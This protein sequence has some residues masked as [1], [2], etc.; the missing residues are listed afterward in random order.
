MSKALACNETERQRQRQRGRD[1]IERHRA[2]ETK[3]KGKE[4]KGKEEEGEKNWKWR[5]LLKQSLGVRDK[6]PSVALCTP[7]R[8]LKSPFL[9][10][11]KWLTNGKKMQWASLGSVQIEFLIIPLTFHCIGNSHLVL[12]VS[13]SYSW[14][15]MW[16][17]YGYY[18]IDLHI[19]SS[20]WKAWPDSGGASFNSSLWRQREVSSLV[21]NV[22]SRTAR[23]H[24]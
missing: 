20:Q 15:G 5:H 10:K 22:G 13:W 23:V 1:E 3:E 17:S 16:L 21:Y 19:S 18:P 6:I 12:P 14:E 4:G 7:C 8:S 2:T 9:W 11:W 24:T